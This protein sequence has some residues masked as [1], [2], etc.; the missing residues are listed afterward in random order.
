MQDEHKENTGTPEKT[1]IRLSVRP[2]IE[3]IMADRERI[4]AG[5]SEK[6]AERYD[7]ACDRDDGYGTNITMFDDMEDAMVG[8][9]VN[10]SGIVVP[11][12]ERELCIISRARKYMKSGDYESYDKAYEAAAEWFSY[13]TERALPYLKEKAPV[14]ISGFM[15]DSEQWEGFLDG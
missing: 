7:E 3:E 9:T 5:Y 14:I 1:E 2:T 4:K 10:E 13:N 8:T 15:R 6:V 12:Y 11:V